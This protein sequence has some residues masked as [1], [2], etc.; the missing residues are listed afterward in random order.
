MEESSR[1][2]TGPELIALCML[3]LVVAVFSWLCAIFFT[4]HALCRGSVQVPAVG[5][6]RSV[7][8]TSLTGP[9]ARLRLRA[10][11]SVLLGVALAFGVAW[12]VHVI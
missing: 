1:P 3:V 4:V 5:V 2:L 7:T 8:G 6:Q 11:V 12:A 10:S 9:R